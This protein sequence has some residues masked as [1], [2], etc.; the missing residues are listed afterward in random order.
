MECLTRQAVAKPSSAPLSALVTST[1]ASAAVASSPGSASAPAAAPATPPASSAI[2]TTTTNNVPTPVSCSTNVVTIPVPI[3]SQEDIYTYV[4]IKGSLHDRTTAVF[5]LNNDEVLA[6]SKRFENGTTQI[7]NGII[8]N[9]PPMQLINTLSQL[10]YKVIC[11]TG[12][13]E[14]VWTMQREV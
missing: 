13:A 12:E 4:S 2:P 3:V 7:V 14:I 5:G 6:L 1:T 11:S 10:G 9:T 8:I